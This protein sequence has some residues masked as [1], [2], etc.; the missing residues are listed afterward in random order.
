[1]S[2]IDNGKTVGQKDKLQLEQNH[3]GSPSVCGIVACSGC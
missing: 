1:M 2:Q 3:A